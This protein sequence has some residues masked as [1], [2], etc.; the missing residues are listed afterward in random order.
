MT[1]EEK[2][3][4]IDELQAC[5]GEE[6]VVLDGCF[7]SK[8]CR[9]DT[10]RRE[11]FK[12]DITVRVVKNTLLRKAM[13]R[14]KNDLRRACMTCCR[15]NCFDDGRCGQCACEA[16]Q[17]FP[18]EQETPNSKSAYVEEAC[19]V[20]ADQLEALTSIKIERRTPWRDYWLAPDP[21]V[22]NVVGALQSGGNTISGLVK[23]L[24]NAKCD[25]DNIQLIE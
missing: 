9:H 19:Y 18:Q 14:S 7:G 6:C 8:F 10:L 17:G 20:G 24:A 16:D 21:D 3:Q 2:N 23:A 1:R 5:S 25:F 22:K 15:A 4:V 13:E 12:K 11:C